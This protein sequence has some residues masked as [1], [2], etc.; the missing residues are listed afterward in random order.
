MPGEV[1]VYNPNSRAL[2]SGKTRRR[3]YRALKRTFRKARKYAVKRNVNSIVGS[4]FGIAG[5]G[6]KQPFPPRKNIVLT[7]VTSHNLNTTSGL[8]TF[9][10]EKVF[11]LNSLYSPE[12]SGGH[13]YYYFDQVCASGQMYSRYKV[14]AIRVRITFT[15]VRGGD[16]ADD[17]EN[18]FGGILL[19]NIAT[20]ESLNG[21]STHLANELPQVKL[22]Q[23]SSSGDRPAVIDVYIP[24]HK[25]FGWNKSAY[26]NDVSNTTAP[27]SGSPG[28][29]PTMRL[30]IAALSAPTSVCTAYAKVEMIAYATL[31]ARNIV[32]AS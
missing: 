9:G 29:I 1:V 6:R 14:N 8:T 28:S 4:A 31:Y 17:Q 18:C 20:S 19:N 2:V 25:L 32:G 13:Q 24:L 21:K 10:S 3:V 11:N 23:L 30:A 7:Y 12:A 26:R 5:F 16:S 15:G 27:Y 22:V